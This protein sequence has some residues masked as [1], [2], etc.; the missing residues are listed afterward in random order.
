MLAEDP[1]ICVAGSNAR[2]RM[3]RYAELFDE[4]HVVALTTAAMGS[5]EQWG[6]PARTTD[7]LP[8]CVIQ[9]GVQ[10]GGLFLHPA[11][12][13]NPLVQRWRM[14]SIASSLA[15]DA[16]FDMVTSQ[17]PDEAG[18]IAYRI[19]RRFG[20]KLQVQV[21][22]D[23]LSTWYR[24]ASW[25]EYARYLLARY[26][27]PRADCI[28][29]VSGRIKRSL[30][31]ELRIPESK[32]F[33][34]PIF[35][36]HRSHGAGFTNL[37]PFS[38]PV[39]QAGARGGQAPRS[40]DLMRLQG[41]AFRIIAVGRFVDKEKNFSML[42]RMMPEMIK[43]EPRAVLVLVGGGPDKAEYQK[44]VARYGLEKNVIIEPWRND[45]ASFYKC[46]NVALISSNYEGWGLVA[47]EAMA[48]GVP[49]VMTDV[50]LAGEVIKDGI[51][52]RV[53]PVG[54]PGAFLGAVL[55]LHHHP[56]KRRAFADAARRTI[57][58]MKPQSEAEYLQKYK[59][60]FERCVDKS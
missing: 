39:P 50:G 60:S 25:K 29:V 42:I 32:I 16:H 45:L 44:Q 26:L 41:Y 49:V 4:L 38:L 8:D 1:N 33:V 47:I 57:T 18:F 9:A 14:Y 12:A 34:L 7:I 23:V 48:A 11:A 40:E 22:T 27:L 52:G 2:K 56:K 51:N 35:T 37:A 19:A 36:P 59:E 28:R 58:E 21:H 53:V 46:F 3:E 20:I 24:R 5:P 6:K 15:A 13:K 54:D 43:K 31:A 55:D 30:V 10:S 17:G